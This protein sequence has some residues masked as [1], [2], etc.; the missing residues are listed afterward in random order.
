MPDTS[1]KPEGAGLP[2]QQATEGPAD[3]RSPST[4]LPT[5]KVTAAAIL[6][7]LIVG[8]FLIVFS[9]ERCI[10]ALGYFF[11]Y[12][13]DFFKF[14]GEAIWESYSALFLGAVGSG[15]AI[16]QTLER[17][18]PLICAGLGVSLAFRSGLFNIGAQG[19]LIVGAICAG[20]VGFTYS[21]PPGLHLLAALVA[22][23]VGGAVWGGIAGLLKAKTGAHEVITTIMLNYVATSLLL[24]LLTKDAFQRPGSDNPRSLPAADS[25]LFPS[26]GGTHTGVV[27]A[28]LIALGVWW[29]LERSTLGF[30][31]R[32]VGA[33]ADAA[34][35]AGMNVA[36]VYTLAMLV[37]GALAGL[38][39]TMQILGKNDSLTANVAG[40][41]GFDAITVALL[42]RATPLGTVLAGL[43]FGALAAGG[44][45]MQASEAATPLALTQVLQALI[46]L[47]VAAPALVRGVLRFKDT[48]GAATVMA[49]GWGS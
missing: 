23:V 16:S 1:V 33:N 31:L 46:V 22:G 2:E 48:G 36:K 41:L 35:T 9:D 5:V 14:A 38:A 29:L 7:A 10:E 40:S 43:L 12:P 20:Y 27:V 19:Q 18:A 3:L 25:S 15:R 47:F 39:A 8:A 37:A 21:L 26:V 28:I 11:D 17:A 6:L 4:W 32:A 45:Q 24:Y 34:R 30:E 13:W 44:V 42:G 49:K